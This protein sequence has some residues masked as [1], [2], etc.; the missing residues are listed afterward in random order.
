LR[1]VFDRLQQERGYSVQA[2]FQGWDVLWK[3]LVNTAIYR[4]GADLSETGSTWIAALVAMNA[5]RPFARHEIDQLGGPSAFLPSAWQNVS[6]VDDPQVWAIPFMADARVIY[7]WRDMLQQAGL[8]P[9]TAFLS[10]EQCAETCARLQR[11][12]ATPWVDMTD[13]NRHDILYHAASWI[14]A[15]GGDFLSLDGKRVLV[16]EPAARAGLRS[17][18]GLHRFMPRTGQP[19][20]NMHAIDLFFDRQAAALMSGP[21][22]FILHTV[23]DCAF[24]KV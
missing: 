19:L 4:R 22:L 16:G 1:Q 24:S 7:Y 13:P 20:D 5:L 17:Y 18:F 8:D 11:V 15:K 21:W 23:T 12:V 14:W 6:L 2:T 10:P 9:Q 3:E